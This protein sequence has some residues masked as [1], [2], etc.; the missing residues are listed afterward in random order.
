MARGV[1]KSTFEAARWLSRFMELNPDPTS[2]QPILTTAVRA[3]CSTCRGSSLRLNESN[4]NP[5]FNYPNLEK[6]NLDWGQPLPYDVG[7]FLNE[8]L[9]LNSSWKD[10]EAYVL[11]NGLRYITAHCPKKAF[12]CRLGWFGLTPSESGGLDADL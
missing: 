3:L 4:F 10:S 12:R 11:E 8:M 2:V 7:R 9:E 6:H 5:E 1:A